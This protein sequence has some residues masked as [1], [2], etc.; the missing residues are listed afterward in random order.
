[1]TTNKKSS[2][3]KIYIV[4]IIFALLL[5]SGIWIVIQGP[6]LDD[7]YQNKKISSMKDSYVEIKKA[8][9]QF[10]FNSE[11]FDIVFRKA[12]EKDNVEIVIRDN[13]SSNLKVST[14]EYEVLAFDLMSYIFGKPSNISDEEIEI[15]EDYEIHSVVDNKTRFSYIDMWGRIDDEIL[16]LMRSPIEGIRE[17]IT[18]AKGF[19]TIIVVVL[20]VALV[21]SII[22]FIRALT[23]LELRTKNEQLEKDIQQKEYLEKMRS[24]FLSNVSHELKTPL[25]IVQGYAEGLTDLTDGNSETTK[26]YCDVILDETSKMN[27]IVQKLI[28]INKI[29]FGEIKHTYESFDIVALVKGYV[30]S[31][32]ILLKSNNISFYMQEYEPILVYSDISSIEEVLN[33]YFSNAIHYAKNEKTIKINIKEDDEY[34]TVYIYNSGEKIPEESLPHLFEKFY[35]VDAARTREYGGS[36]VG[37]SIAKALLDSLDEKYGVV[38]VSDGVEFFFTVRRREKNT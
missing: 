32:E 28:N 4:V 21:F 37:L 36:G 35:K 8:A 20:T 15:A 33:N 1:M 10:G 16:F 38:N 14:N 23:I 30:S 24:E 6:V 3:K 5:I 29:E 19:L 18:V 26:Y 2:Y 25:A 31:T 34:V 12:V 9:K 7:Y 11:E 27:Q 22:L 17:S 13:E